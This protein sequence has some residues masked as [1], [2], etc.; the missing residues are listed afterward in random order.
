MHVQTDHSLVTRLPFSPFT[1]D[2]KLQG[3][4]GYKTVEVS[5]NF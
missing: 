5:V 1:D 3:Q 2:S 4:V